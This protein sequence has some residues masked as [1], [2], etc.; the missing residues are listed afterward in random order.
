VLLSVAFVP[1]VEVL[2]DLNASVDASGWRPGDLERIPSAHMQLSVAAFGNVARNEMA[3]LC[4]ALSRLAAA[5]PPAPAL[6]FAG[7]AAL[8]WPGD[9]R[10][11]AKLDG[12]VDALQGV[13]ASIAPA[14]LPLGYA[15][16]RRRFRPWLPLGTVTPT[17][18]LDFLERLVARLDSHQGPP[19]EATHLSLVSPVFDKSRSGSSA[20]EI[21][22][23]F[24]LPTA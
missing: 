22:R 4:S 23:E 10:V 11:W 6:H 17:T 9:Q 12:D 19:W 1:P 3:S 18:G 8:E 16:D 13:A 20:F 15:I 21:V 14:M 2:D 7:G 24:A 5:W